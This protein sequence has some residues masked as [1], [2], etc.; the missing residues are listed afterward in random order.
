MASYI[1][2]SKSRIKWLYLRL[3][4]LPG[5][6]RCATGSLRSIHHLVLLFGSVQLTAQLNH[7]WRFTKASHMGC[8]YSPK[9]KCPYLLFTQHEKVIALNSKRCLTINRKCQGRNYWQT[10]VNKAFFKKK[11][12]TFQ[13]LLVRCEFL[14]SFTFYR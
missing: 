4:L 3:T 5:L 13:Y 7:K 2:H 1:F 14:K 12:I 11:D 6:L 8:I 10:S 9:E